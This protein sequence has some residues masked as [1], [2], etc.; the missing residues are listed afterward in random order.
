[1][2]L[3]SDSASPQK[4]TTEHFRLPKFELIANQM[5]AIHKAVEAARPGKN[6]LKQFPDVPHGWM[7][8]R[9]DVSPGFVS[10]RS[11]VVLSSLYNPLHRAFTCYIH[12][13]GD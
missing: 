1:M 9:G 3:L 13:S 10:L 11:A 4:D 12:V 2:S 8:A 6:F 5:N 7:A